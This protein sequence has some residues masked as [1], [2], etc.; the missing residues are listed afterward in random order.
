MSEPARPTRTYG[1]KEVGKIL[2]RATELQQTEPTAVSSGGM[3]LAEL[4]EVAA[5]A[6]IDVRR[7]RR[8]AMEFD[9]GVGAS[10]AWAG[11]LGAEL[12]VVRE[13]IVPGEVPERRFEDLLSV[14]QSTVRD[15]GHPSLVGRTLTWQAGGSESA[16]KLRVV[17]SS[18]GGE[19]TLRV[20]ENL[21]QM[22]GGLFGGI[23]GGVGV[24]VG[25]GFGL[26]LGLSVGSAV[27][28]AAFPV[29]WLGLTYV[30]VRTLYRTLVRRRRGFVDELFGRLLETAQDAISE[31]TLEAG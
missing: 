11:F 4:E 12:T 5:E 14:L 21:S 23:G 9:A 29:A 10:D 31:T 16:R 28:M 17:V 26:P 7:V 25:I 2:E 1:E 27:A 22:A 8:A 15:H 6:G 30:G 20:E 13:T 24:G 19:T 3:T 18:R